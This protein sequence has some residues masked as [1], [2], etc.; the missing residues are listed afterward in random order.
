MIDKVRATH[1]PCGDV[2]I[3]SNRFK[4]THN[5]NNDCEPYSFQFT[6]HCGSIVVKQATEGVFNLLKKTEGV[7]DTV[8][9][10]N[11]RDNEQRGD[12]PPITSET[13]ERM[14]GLFCLIPT[15]TL[16]EYLD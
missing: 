7:E 12:L 9:Y 3:N 11:P 6:C 13:A 10:R 14:L 15:D 5:L 16:V 8:L 2:I 1:E 4:V